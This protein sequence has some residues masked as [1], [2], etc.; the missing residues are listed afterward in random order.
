M[1][2]TD[3]IQLKITKVGRNYFVSDQT[4]NSKVSRLPP[5]YILV[6]AIREK[7][8]N[9]HTYQL[10]KNR[11]YKVV[12]R[13]MHPKTDI[14]H[15]THHSIANT[16]IQAIDMT[17][18]TIRGNITI[19]AVYCPP[20]HYSSKTK[21]PQEKILEQTI[22]KLSLD[23]VMTGEP[24]YWPQAQEKTP[25]LL[26]FAVINSLHKTDFVAIIL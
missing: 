6:L 8:A 5:I 14:K 3:N 11:N 24:I 26:D 20:K 13:R 4:N 17:I 22:R 25:D 23:T 1:A 18:H 10:K 12:L 21:S 15:N 2:Q 7:N 9:F 16:H 19:A